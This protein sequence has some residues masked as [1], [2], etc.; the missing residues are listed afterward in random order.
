MLGK[1]VRFQQVPG[2]A[3]KAQLIQFGAN[4]VFAQGIVDMLIAKN[5]GMDNAQP[6]TV[7]NTTPTTFE[8]WCGEVLK[9][10]LLT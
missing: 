7:E 1:P 2:D 4:E 8:Q 3:Y 10:A 5:K 9:P 6:R